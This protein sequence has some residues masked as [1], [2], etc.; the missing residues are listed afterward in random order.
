MK[1][2]DNTQI[3][4]VVVRD[5]FILDNQEHY[6]EITET[7]PCAVFAG[8]RLTEAQDTADAYNQKFKDTGIEGF[9]FRVCATAL[10]D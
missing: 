5:K 4:Y 7:V 2:A 8:D 6:G 1:L 9:Q 3:C 10:Y